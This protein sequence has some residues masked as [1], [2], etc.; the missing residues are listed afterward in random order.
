M[1]SNEYFSIRTKLFI[2]ANSIF[3][4]GTK[5]SSIT[6]IKFVLVYLYSNKQSNRYSINGDT[7][8]VLNYKWCLFGEFIIYEK[9]IYLYIR[10]HTLHAYILYLQKIICIY[11]TLEF[12]N[13]NSKPIKFSRVKNR[14]NKKHK[15]TNSYL[16]IEQIEI[17]FFKPAIIW[18]VDNK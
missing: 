7:R 13:W 18:F 4:Y 6:K 9:V 3:I 11:D 16:G 15:T 8:V 12:G 5:V 1:T 14:F 2:S 10:E 17:M